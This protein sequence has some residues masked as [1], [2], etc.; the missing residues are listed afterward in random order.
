MGGYGNHQIVGYKNLQELVQK[1]H[2]VA[3][4]V[5]KEEALDLPEMVDEIRYVT[6]DPQG[7]KIYESLETSSYAELL[8]V[9]WL[10]ET[11]LHSCFACSR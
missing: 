10:L 8:K 3:Y 5:T 7:M 9:R 4:R 11:S 6:L 2:S 1:A